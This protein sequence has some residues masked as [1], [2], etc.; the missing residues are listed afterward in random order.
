M[1]GDLSSRDRR[2][3]AA[4]GSFEAQR[5]LAAEEA[6]EAERLA[7]ENV[8]SERARE[9]A[10]LG[11]CGAKA[12]QA[13]AR[14]AALSRP[15]TAEDDAR[16]NS[17]VEFVGHYVRLVEYNRRI[18]E[19]ETIELWRA[20][21]RSPGTTFS[22]KAGDSA[23]H[24]GLIFARM[25]LTAT[26]HARL[27]ALGGHDLDPLPV[28]PEPDDRISAWR[29]ATIKELREN[30]LPPLPAWPMWEIHRDYD[31]LLCKVAA[32]WEQAMG[33]VSGNAIAAD[34]LSLDAVVALFQNAV[35]EFA[36]VRVWLVVVEGHH[37][38]PKL[39]PTIT[40]RGV[41]M[42]D[43]IS[44]ITVNDTQRDAGPYEVCGVLLHKGNATE[45]VKT[46]KHLAAKAGAWLVANRIVSDVPQ[47]LS[48]AAIWWLTVHCK[49]APAHRNCIENKTVW[50]H[51]PLVDSLQV[52]AGIQERL[53]NERP[54]DTARPG[55]RRKEAKKRGAPSTAARDAEYLAEFE[56]GEYKSRADFARAKKME[57][58]A[59]RHL[60]RRAAASRS[61]KSTRR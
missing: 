24:V 37:I 61:T 38:P 53:A 57:P 45:A 30:T 22:W 42:V 29:D 1:K 43:A 46:C 58:S 50:L 14:L 3:A 52:L 25:I 39:L 6:D 2:L 11:A 21:P 36:N 12:F 27:Q 59:M 54:P 34:P 20:W 26:E 8:K 60:L 40:G 49:L 44:P 31:A 48:P 17:T 41:C 18:A 7:V 19:L 4:R 16:E 23:L 56:R 47:G 33:E 13:A 51:D 10:R 55:D 35:A 32:E 28:A 9:L 5:W 15:G